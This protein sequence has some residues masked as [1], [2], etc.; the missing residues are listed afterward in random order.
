MTSTTQ[1]D[2]VIARG[3]L[4]A[5][6]WTAL[7]LGLL[8]AAW[9]L[10]IVVADLASHADEWDGLGIF[11]GLAFALPALVPCV[12]AGLALRFRSVRRPVGVGLGVL[13][14]TPV[15]WVSDAPLLLVPMVV[16]V[17]LVVVA[18]LGPSL[19]EGS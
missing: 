13:L 1:A 9:G 17:G 6:L 11:I 8:V 10:L 4:T 19:A 18:L 7:V 14:V 3:A 5:L 15:L 12:L 16:G 2:R